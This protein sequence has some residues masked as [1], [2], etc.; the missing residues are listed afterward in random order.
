MG[1][2][3]DDLSP[4]L[5]FSQDI[6]GIVCSFYVTMERKEK[7]DFALFPTWFEV[8]RLV[9]PAPGEEYRLFAFIGPFSSTVI[10]YVMLCFNAFYLIN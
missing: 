8:F 3:C 9:V 5:A 2:K 1:I 4:S 7:M 6:D 10:C